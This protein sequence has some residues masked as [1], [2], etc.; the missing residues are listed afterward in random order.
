MFTALADSVES[1]AA[2]SAL[3]LGRDSVASGIRLCRNRHLL[4]RLRDP[5]GGV[6]IT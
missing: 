4:A 1:E 3:P 6:L 2:V 5:R